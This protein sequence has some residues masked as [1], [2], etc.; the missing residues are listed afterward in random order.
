MSAISARLCATIFAL[1]VSLVTV[2]SLAPPAAA[3]SPSSRVIAIA[4][5]ERG[6]PYRLGAEGPRAFDC[7]GFVYYVFRRAHLL[8]RIG[9]ARLRA[10]GYLAWFRDRGLASR[11]NPRRGD[12]VVWGGGSHIG[13][14][15]GDGK[16]IS[17]V[18]TGVRIHRISALDRPFTTYLH[19]HLR[20]T[21]D[22][23][24]A[25][26]T[27]VTARWVRLRAH[28]S[29]RSHTV[30][31]LHPGT[32]LAVLKAIR[33]TRDRIWYRVRAGRAD[34]GWVAGWLTRAG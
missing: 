19:T 31:L 21:S 14:Y 20:R 17:A 23:R 4:K 26:S 13:I 24:S 12:L 34:V 15:V 18:L 27:R 1:V 2:T 6:S 25:A 8:D 33:S 5:S 29:F 32:H 22:T 16:A 7:S 28:A 11:S 30:R 9:G 10:R 3:Q